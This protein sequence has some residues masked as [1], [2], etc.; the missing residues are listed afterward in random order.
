[1]TVANGTLTNP[2]AQIGQALSQREHQGLQALQQILSGQLPQIPGMPSG[3][4]R[5]DLR[6]TQQMMSI[7]LQALERDP[8]LDL[9]AFEQAF[10]QPLLSSA[11]PGQLAAMD[12]YRRRALQTGNLEA[13]PFAQLPSVSSRA[14]GAY[15]QALSQLGQEF[16]HD[17]RYQQMLG[18]FIG[19]LVPGGQATS[20]PTSLLAAV[21]F[22]YL[23]QVYHYGG[24]P[25]AAGLPQLAFPTSTEGMPLPRQQVI[26]NIARMALGTQGMAVTPTG[27]QPMDAQTYWD[28]ILQSAQDALSGLIGL[29]GFGT[30]TF[31][32]SAMMGVP[33][34]TGGAPQSTTT[35]TPAPTTQTGEPSR[36]DA[37]VQAIKNQLSQMGA[38][39]TW[40]LGSLAANRQRLIRHIGQE[41][42]NE[43]MA[44]A[45][46]NLPHNPTWT[47]PWGVDPIQAAL[48]VLER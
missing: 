29:P 24:D 46:I 34:A 6:T 25:S 36:P 16:G 7:A 8:T 45:Q 42:W 19:S 40:T 38:S 26:E 5:P 18:Q 14:I 32:A 33:G 10:V 41:G 28:R 20:L 22:P 13:F 23:Q 43:L 47:P 11:L 37:T 2:Y 9:S 17:P 30:A 39:A 15:S 1:M 4:W 31:D 48:A 44:W 35:G 12:Y 3:P 27:V 21:S